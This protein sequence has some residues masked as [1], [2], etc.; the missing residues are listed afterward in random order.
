MTKRLT[1][2]AAL[3]LAAGAVCGAQSAVAKQPE[4]QWVGTWAASPMLALPGFN[5]RPFTGETL[6]E[7]VHLSNGGD[8]V[9]VRFTNEFGT[10][11]LTISDAHVALSAGG[12][13]PSR[14][15]QITR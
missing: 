6:R 15:A 5:V 11:P 2:L 7:I 3:L 14:T 10:D 4:P 12:G 13:G 8:R 1:G 9:R